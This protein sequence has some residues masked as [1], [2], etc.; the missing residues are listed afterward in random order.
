M[1][2]VLAHIAL[3]VLEIIT[4]TAGSQ[5]MIIPVKRYVLYFLTVNKE[6]IKSMVSFE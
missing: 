5:I 2:G 6:V 1:A 3:L 4:V